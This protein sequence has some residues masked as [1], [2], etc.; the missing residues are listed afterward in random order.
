[1]PKL[2]ALAARRILA[3]IFQ[4]D[5]VDGGGSGGMDVLVIFKCR[6]HFFVLRQVGRQ[7]QLDLGIIETEQRIAFSGHESGSDFRPSSVRVGMFCKLGSVE[8]RRPVAATL[9]L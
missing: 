7:A 2:T 4:V 5:A 3:Y 8:E 1:M 9:W 6:H